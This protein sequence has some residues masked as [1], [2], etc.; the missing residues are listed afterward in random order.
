MLWN[1][2]RIYYYICGITN[3]QFVVQ[4]VWMCVSAHAKSRNVINIYQQATGNVGKIVV[5]T[6]YYTHM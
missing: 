1:I 5:D 2:S 4:R 6:L 3:G